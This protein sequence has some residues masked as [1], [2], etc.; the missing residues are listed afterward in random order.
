MRLKQRR[1]LLSTSLRDASFPSASQS[2]SSQ[3]KAGRRL[4]GNRGVSRPSALLLSCPKKRGASSSASRS[5]RAPRRGTKAGNRRGSERHLKSRRLLSRE[6]RRPGNGGTL[7]RW[8]RRRRRRRVL[9]RRSTC[10]VS[11]CPAAGCSP[12]L[13]RAGFG[14]C[15]PLGAPLC[16]QLTAR[17]GSWPRGAVRKGRRK[18]LRGSA[19]KGERAVVAALRHPDWA[20]G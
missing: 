7:Q 20:S 9:R 1:E 17:G 11:F 13:R 19:G 15:R 10:R 16:P 12:R 2:E 5:A 18:M 14:L 8:R 3:Q 4:H 6:Q